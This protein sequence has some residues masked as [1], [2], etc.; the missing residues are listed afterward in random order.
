MD[1]EFHQLDLRFAHLRVRRPDRERKLLASLAA[2]G[3]QVPI[4]VVAVGDQGRQYLVI[5]G[6]KRVAAL[7]KLGQDT[8]RA[9]VWQMN[10]AEALLLGQSL[11]SS[12]GDSALEQG[13]LMSELEHRFGFSLEEL[14][15]RFDRSVSWV[16]R[17]LAL[18]ELLPDAVQEKVRRGDITPHVAMRFLVPVAR[19]NPQDCR[20]M[21]EAFSADKFSSREAA[22]L[23]AAWRDSSPGMRVRILADPALFLK[24][25]RQIEKARA[26]DER[27][28]AELLR[29]LEMV[30]AIAR[31]AGRRWRQTAVLMDGTDIDRAR[32]CLEHALDELR[33]LSQRMEQ[34]KPDAEQEPTHD[35]SG[36]ARPGDEDT[37][38]CPHAADLPSGGA[39]SA[40]FELPRSPG[41]A[42]SRKSRA[43]PATDP[44]V[45]ARPAR[46]ISCESMRNWL[47]G[48]AELS[49]PALTA[50][51]RRH[52]IGQAPM[53][54]AG[55]YHFEPGEEMQHDTSP[56]E[57]D[58]GG[59]QAQGADRLGRAVLLAHAV[60]SVLSRRSSVS[61]ARSFSP[62]RCATSAA[63]RA[64]HDRQHARGGV[65]RHRARDGSGARD[66]GV[67]R[68]L[69]LPLRGA[70]D[71]RC[72]PFG[73]RG[74]AV[75]ASSRTTFWPAA[76]SPDWED[77]N[78]RR[79]QWCDHVNATYKK[80]I[81]AV[82]RE[83]F[84]V[85]RLHLK[86]LPAWIPE[87][88]RLHQRMVDVEGYVALHSNRY[89]VPVVWIGRRV[90]V[91]ETR[92]KIE[93]QLDARHLVAHRRVVDAE[94][95]RVTL[96]EHRPPRGQG[97]KRTDPHPEE[98]GHRSQPRPELGRLCRGR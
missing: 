53:V 80:H 23:Y 1:L 19:A 33:R 83:L 13:W 69:R 87:V 30:S 79:A 6:H 31:R 98:T 57:V 54:P 73:A 84:A 71:R 5:D 4:V 42:A 65:A 3:Q 96:A 44:G 67:R 48:G 92:D 24:A 68:A 82:P 2:S 12:D 49:Y 76:R 26:P 16:S 46:A 10:E 9:T 14:A 55:H 58:V 27:A 63:R 50:F 70:R 81:R 29:D 41:A 90:E 20:T 52:G 93:I 61:T 75:L 74:T 56:H 51:C 78:H 97:V 39:Q 85:E 62:T 88:Y 15:R 21:A 89:S 25:R 38:D 22:E 35:D 32:H 8:V 34:E 72:Q 17:R 7:R 64:R 91:R 86:P 66:G 47:A 59:Q 45:A 18:V 43:L 95:Q 94:A 40:A 77:L 28:S 36:T 37:R 11:R 60:L